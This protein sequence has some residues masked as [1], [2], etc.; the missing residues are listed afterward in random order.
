M[1][2]IWSLSAEWR[3]P[4]GLAHNEELTHT[5]LSAPKQFTPRPYQIAATQFLLENDRCALFVEPGLGKTS[6]TLNAIELLNLSGMTSQ[7]LIVAPLRVAKDTWINEVRKW[8][9]MQSLTI[10]A[11]VG[12]PEQRLAALRSSAQIKTINYENLVWLADTLG[13]EW[14]FKTV[15]FDESSKLKSF[16]AHFKRTST[17][18]EALYRTGGARAGAIIRQCFKKTERVWLLTGTPSSNSLSAL[19]PQMFFIDAGERLGKSFSV[20]EDRWYKTG[21]NGHDKELLPHAEVEI[22]ERIKDRVFTLQ[23]ADYLNLGKEVIINISIDLPPG[24]AKHYRNMEED[25]YIQINNREVEAFSA[26]AKSMKLHQ[27][28]NGGI[29]YDEK[30]SWEHAHD[31]KLDALESLIEEACGMPVIVIYKFKSDLL[32]LQ[33]RFKQGKALDTRPKTMS[34]FLDGEIPVLFLHPASA[35]H[36]L[37]DMEKVTNLMIFFSMD[38]DNE[39]RQQVC[40]RIGAV[41]QKQSGLERPSFFYNLVAKDTID[42][43]IL[44][45]LETKQTVE[46]TLK[47]GLARRNLK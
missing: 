1:R 46:Q 15:V 43:D 2:G 20:F 7:V 5:H 21:Y 11:I 44:M 4:G 17:G 42:E 38:W 39:L 23:A 27:L 18:K 6:C 37:N 8:R 12:T 41:R 32:R 16:R 47:Q 24:A 13:N 34:Q 30:G 29:Y 31:A 14:P 36:G 25:F 10:T 19:W 33:A 40:A 3:C 22:R 26:A 35:G 9:H 28:A 45:R